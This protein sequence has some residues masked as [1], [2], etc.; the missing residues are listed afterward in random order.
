MTWNYDVPNLPLVTIDY[1]EVQNSYAYSTS[2]TITVED[3]PAA[4]MSIIA[5][6]KDSTNPLVNNGRAIGRIGGVNEG[7]IGARDIYA[8]VHIEAE[9]G[10][11]G[12]ISA[13]NDIG[14]KGSVEKIELKARTAID[15]I[16]AGNNLGRPGVPIEIDVMGSGPGDIITPQMLLGQISGTWMANNGVGVKGGII[17]AAGDIYMDI[18]SGASIGAIQAN[19]GKVVGDY[20]ATGNLKSVYGSLG[21]DGDFVAELGSM[22]FVYAPTGGISGSFYAG[23]DIGITIGTESIGVYSGKGD[24]TAD[25]TAG[26]EIKKIEVL[27][28]NIASEIVAGKGI[29]EIKALVGN[30][31]GK[32][33]SGGNIGAIQEIIGAAKGDVDI[34]LKLVSGKSS[35]LLCSGLDTTFAMTGDGYALMRTGDTFEIRAIQLFGTTSTSDF[36]I[37]TLGSKLLAIDSFQVFGDIDS[38]TDTGQDGAADVNIA[39]LGVGGKIFG[40]VAVEGVI[41]TLV[42]GGIEENGSVVTNVLSGN[43]FTYTVAGVTDTVAVADGNWNVSVFDGNI[44]SANLTKVMKASTTLTFKTTSSVED[45][46]AKLAGRVLDLTIGGDIIG[47]VD[48]HSGDLVLKADDLIGSVVVTAGSVNALDL[49]GKLSGSLSADAIAD[50]LMIFNIGGDLTGTIDVKGDLDLNIGGNFGNKTGLTSSVKVGSGT[51]ELDV[52]GNI[53]KLASATADDGFASFHHGGTIDPALGKIIHL[54]TDPTTLSIPDSY[55]TLG[56]L[57]QVISVAGSSPSVKTDLA[58]VFDSLV[59]SVNI[60][61]SGWFSFSSTGLPGESD[62]GDMTVASGSS[63]YIGSI[64]VDGN[65]GGYTNMN[66][67]AYTANIEAKGDIGQVVGNGFIYNIKAGGSIGEVKSIS[68]SWGFVMNIYAGDEIKKIFTPGYVMNVN[69]QGNIGSISAGYYAMYIN[70]GGKIDE[71]LGGYGVMIVNAHDIGMINGGDNGF[72]Y[73]ITTVDDIDP[74][75]EEALKI[76]GKYVI[77]VNAGGKKVNVTSSGFIFGVSSGRIPTPADPFPGG[78]VVGGAAYNISSNIKVVPGL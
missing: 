69:A 41:N 31:S 37:T 15:T 65:L 71:I 4:M 9:K 52:E 63:I 60:S 62:I 26:G 49:D 75:K 22:D 39:N 32:I 14:A 44:I 7:I 67:W 28:G 13:S 74:T 35:T 20:H 33:Y 6:G 68:S 23:R 61:G 11:I 8:N 38:L 59:T 73:N 45:L 27:N 46:G 18:S 17:A 66:D 34:T 40:K 30:V 50:E 58:I 25:F 77:N 56:G 54:D 53:F 24:I 48:I 21:V 12:E 36:A 55:T 2:K 72:V 5:K 64:F 16:F 10:G 51:L 43:T 57:G 19:A 78:T 42:A 70:S 3:E 1:I 76:N 47:T 29:G